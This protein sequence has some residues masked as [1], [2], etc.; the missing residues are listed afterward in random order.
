MLKTS[1]R[2][3]HRFI[4]SALILA[5]LSF[6][7]IVLSLRYW[8]LPNIA[9]Y[10]HIISA[11]ITRAAGQRVDIGSIAAGWDGL[12]PHLSLRQ[13]QVYDR[14][15][16]P[17]LAFSHIEGTLAWWSLALGEVRLYS[18]EIDQ[19]TLPMHRTARGEIYVGGV[20]VNQPDTES[21]FADW[22][23]RQHRVLVRGATVTWQDDMRHAPLLVL[24]N[25]NLR[26]ENRGDRHRFGLRA[27]PP[28]ALAMPLDVRGD[29]KV[30]ALQRFADWSGTLY[31]RLDYANITA[32]R[33]WLDLPFQ[34]ERG[35]GGVRAWVTIGN[36]QARAVT[37]DVRLDNVLTRLKPELPQL[38]LQNV[39]GRL[40]WRDLSPGVELQ[41]S[42]LSFTIRDAL[43]FGPTSAHFKS[44]PERVKKPAAVELQVDGLAFAPLLELAAY[45]PLDGDVREKLHRLQPKGVLSG[46]AVSWSGTWEAPIHYAVKGKFADLAVQPY[47]LSP[48][49][50]L[51][52]FSG[53][54]GSIDTNEK[55]GS[56]AVNARHR[57]SL[58]LPGVFDHT[59]ELDTLTAQV[60]WSSKAGQREFKLAS[61][62]F[63]NSHLA[64]TASGS[65]TTVANGPGRIDLNGKLS[66]ADARFVSSY[67]PLVVGKETRDWLEKSLK[68]GRSDDVRLRLKGDLANFPFVDGKSG[69]FEVAVKGSGGVLEYA[70]GWPA[71]EGISVDLL[72]RGKSMDIYAR[73]AHTYGM[74]LQ[75]VHVQIADL[76]VTDELLTVDGE[77]RGPTADMLKF[78]A[79]SPVNDMIEGFTEGMQ[80]TGNGLFKLSLKI[81]LRR[82]DDMTVAG[83]YAFQNNNVQLGAGAPMLEQVNGA[84]QF[85]GSSVVIPRITAQFLGGP[86]SLVAATQ[87]GVV[88]VN[89][90]GKATAAG[91][92]KAFAHP[93][94]RRLQGGAAWTGQITLRKKLADAVFSSNLQGLS[95]EL[96]LPFNKKAADS[97]VLRLE[98]KASSVDQDSISVSYGKV[99]AAQL[100]RQRVGEEMKVERGAIALGG[101]PL[102]LPSSGLWLGGSLPYLDLDFWRGVS[103]QPGAAGAELSVDA[104][105]L[106]LAAVD[107]FGKRFNDLRLNAVARNGS[108]QAALESREMSGNVTWTRGGAGR[109]M[110]R[111]KSLT[112]PSAA[113]PK[114][115]EPAVSAAPAANA[116]NSELPTLD[117]V[118]E[119]FSMRNMQLGHL[120]L[121]AAPSGRD[122]RIEKLKLSTPES[123]L[124]LDGVWQDWLQQPRSRVNLQLETSDV[125]KLLARVGHPD[126][127][128]GGNAKL[129]GQFYWVG[130]PTEFNFATLSGLMSLEA[131]KGQFLKIEPGIGKLLGVLSLQ[132]LPRRITLDFRDIFSDGFAFDDISGSVK[133]N[134]GVVSGNDF[135]MDGPAAKVTMSGEADLARE[136]QNLRVRVVPLFGDT[137]SGAATLLGG[138]V[139]GLT[140]LLVQKMLKDP[141]G[142]INAYE[143]SISGTWDNPVVTKLKKKVEDSKSWDGN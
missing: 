89:A 100:E 86:A 24:N 49:K 135:K 83:S 36:A 2:W 110:G 95:S 65:Y 126:S 7:V 68:A 120:E 33:S 8:L 97:V 47:V 3:L 75:K 104:V 57:M 31:A 46:L 17:A 73:A 29:I 76:L 4:I 50:T 66:R 30:G 1:A 20:W 82:L 52:G 113:P 12:R 25:A 69:L 94:L 72:F 123:T 134:Q 43:T 114:L 45:L 127:V 34:L 55:D 125:G 88:Q 133:V 11:T 136:T 112:V 129:N 107:V 60:K 61:A 103:N 116:A 51:P 132:S 96:P 137:L 117:I 78:V 98:R 42:K 58:D 54:S 93:L 32:W 79:Q 41:A 119:S 91:L 19:P 28:Q 44:V 40:G 37:A 106:N 10:R 109:V 102:K 39:S 85:T 128:K 74:Q 56:A 143:Y 124:S 141:I 21:G 130:S 48:G 6:A 27:V 118:A 108:W 9:E 15:G 59:L 105:N 138:P 139:A 87:Q 63:A 131:H 67:M 70:P 18:L 14:A 142:Q 80:A 16:M 101:G 84:L 22:V 90:S 26:L 13:V 115:S 122:W 77:A 62:S 35:S 53:L 38:D 92:N 23:L 5:G 64:G 71:I 99:L 81:P 140:A 121:L 111:F